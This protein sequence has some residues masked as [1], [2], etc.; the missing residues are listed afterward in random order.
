MSFIKISLAMFF[1]NL[2]MSG[3]HLKLD[4]DIV[5]DNVRKF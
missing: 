1:W 4:K 3:V 5:E 2:Q